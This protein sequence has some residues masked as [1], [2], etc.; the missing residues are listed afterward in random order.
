MKYALSCLLIFSL[1]SN[2]MGQ[3]LRDG[4][5]LK[6]QLLFG[7]LWIDLPQSVLKTELD[8]ARLAM[9]DVFEHEV[10]MR[11]FNDSLE[12]LYISFRKREAGLSRSSIRKLTENMATGFYRGTIYRKEEFTVNG[13]DVFVLDMIGYWNG[14][15]EPSSMLFLVVFTETHTYNLSMRYPEEDFDYSDAIKEEMIYSIRL[16][17]N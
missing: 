4:M 3:G 15:K 8:T 11:K 13:L 1:F 9:R 6:P 12:T 17:E 10:G 14:A 16:K 7:E 5:S 2:L